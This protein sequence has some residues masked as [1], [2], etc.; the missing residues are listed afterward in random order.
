MYDIVDRLAQYRLPIVTLALNDQEIA[1][2]S[3][4]EEKWEKFIEIRDVLA[5]F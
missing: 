1:A 3:L 4:S 5:P 2:Q